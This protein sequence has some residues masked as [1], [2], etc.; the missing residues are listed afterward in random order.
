[1]TNT[2]LSV[3]IVNYKSWK[4]LDNCITS[5]NEFPPSITYEI[6]V[7]DNDSQDGELE[8]FSSQHPDIKFIQNAGNYGFS[9]GCNLGASH[10]EGD[11]L[12]FLNPDTELTED[13]AIDKMITFL[14][15]NQE[16]GI[17]SC[18]TVS[19]KSVERELLFSNPWLLIGFTRQLY[20]LF[21]YK[22][23]KRDFPTDAK[24][25][26]PDW[27]TGSVVLIGK[28]LFNQVGRWNQ[29]RYWMYHED[30]DLCNKVKEA[31]KNIALLRD[32]TIKH[33]GGG[34]S[35]KNTSTTV[36]AK[37]EVIVSSHNYIE[38]NSKSF[39]SVLHLLFG[40]TTLVALLFKSLTSLVFFKFQK[41]KVY[42]VTGISVIKYYFSAI[43]R[44][45][46]KSKK[47]N[48]CNTRLYK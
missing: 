8:S 17:V 26:F 39:R 24:I 1:M 11:Y 44:Q 19:P 45:T 5:F 14:K 47:L 4:L 28:D 21:N 38:S 13:N 43:Y 7:V 31:G 32:V 23:I 9:N 16:M 46:W 35:R 30:P 33:V 18:R 10:A 25:W 48:D 29:E 20:K 34:T 2:E 12:L 3:V 27:V 42:L 22:R 41:S 6:I 37:T 40:M 36:I 15:E